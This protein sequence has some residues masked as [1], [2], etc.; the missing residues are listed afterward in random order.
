MWVRRSHNCIPFSAGYENSTMH[1]PPTDRT[2]FGAF[3]VVFVGGGL[4]HC[5]A[6]LNQGAA[7]S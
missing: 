7:F 1:S 4:H 6:N 5:I 3:D 2:R